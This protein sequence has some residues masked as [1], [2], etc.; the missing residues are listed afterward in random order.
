LSFRAKSR[1]LLSLRKTNPQQTT[2]RRA[3]SM[4][5]D[6]AHRTPRRF[7]SLRHSIL[8]CH[9]EAAP[10]RAKRGEGNEGSVQPG[11]RPVH[12][13]F[14]ILAA[15]RGYERLRMTNLKGMSKENDCVLRTPAGFSQALIKIY[16]PCNLPNLFSCQISSSPACAGCPPKRVWV[17]LPRGVQPLSHPTQCSAPSDF[18]EP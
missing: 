4:G 9:P 14:A 15:D 10:S 17:L 11:L 3:N 12:R 1:D 2:T 13:F 7:R 16:T 5:L 18:L 6:P 8:L